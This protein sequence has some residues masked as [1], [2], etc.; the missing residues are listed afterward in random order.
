M[1]SNTCPHCGASMK[2]YWHNLTPG[3]VNCLIKAIKAV[4]K[5][6]RNVFHWQE[7]GLTTVEANNLQKLRYFGLIAHATKDEHNSGYWLITARGGQFL[8]GELAVPCRVKTFRNRVIDHDTET[9]LISKY[10]GQTGWFESE[11]QFDIRD[12]MLVEMPQ[13]EIKQLSLI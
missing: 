1:Q 12:G 8:R 5:S 6:N 4:K 13:P 11:F 9:M 10:K 2:E 7:L 3:L